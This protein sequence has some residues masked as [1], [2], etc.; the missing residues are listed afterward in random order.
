MRK[1]ANEMPGDYGLPLLGHTISLF[2][3]R[4]I[5]FRDCYK[6]Y[7]SIFKTNLMG[8]KAAVVVDLDICQT[9][10]NNKS[11][12]FSMK[13]G[14]FFLR[15]LLSDGLFLQDGIQHHN[16]RK[17][18][19]PAF[20]GEAIENS[21]KYIETTISTALS[22]WVKEDTVHLAN[23]LHKLTLRISCVLFIGKELNTA[24]ALFSDFV[25]GVTAI[26][27]MNIPYTKFGN[28]IDARN[29]LECLVLKQIL[30]RRHSDNFHHSV[31]ILEVLTKTTD[32]EG[33]ALSDKEIALQIVQFLFAG[34]ETTARL[35]CWSIFELD[36]NKE[37]L[38]EIRKE[39]FESG[40]PSNF[41]YKS[42]QNLTFLEYF[43]LEIERLYPPA[44]FIPRGIV[45]DIEI[46]GYLIPKNWLIFLSP[47]LYHHLP[48]IFKEPDCFDP[49]RYAPP[50]EEHKQHPFSLIGFGGGQHRCLGDLLAKIELKVFILKLVCDYNFFVHTKIDAPISSQP[51]HTVEPKMFMEISQ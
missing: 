22:E 33:I 36:R 29:K 37:I 20:R 16:T 24:E 6:K 15:P 14:W 10:L 2:L 47:P 46:A 27:R 3:K 21:F 26:L 40:V 41:N 35:L 43:V 30:N 34:H 23:E 38:E 42:I 12:F 48:T 13:D 8:K 4:E 32:V 50:R 5:F 39:Y 45:N 49:Y 51:Q 7:G 19:Y 31:D 9:I 17:L 1:Q 44:P 11:N 25:Q 18:L 28:A